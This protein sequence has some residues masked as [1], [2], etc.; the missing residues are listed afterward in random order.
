[1]R[2]IQTAVTLLECAALCAL[3]AVVVAC[4]GS[5]RDGRAPNGVAEHATESGSEESDA[6]LSL[7]VEERLDACAQDPRVLAGLVTQSVCAGADIFFRETFNC[8]RSQRG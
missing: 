5:E 1:M 3:G 4:S 2:S 8:A 6:P 7:S